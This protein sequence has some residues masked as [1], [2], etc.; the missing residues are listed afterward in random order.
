[1]AKK[2]VVVAEQPTTTT[3]DALATFRTSLAQMDDATFAQYQAAVHEES[4]LR[5]RRELDQ[6]FNLFKS[7]PREQQE[8]F[9]QSAQSKVMKKQLAAGQPVVAVSKERNPLRMY[10]DY[11]PE[12]PQYKVA[13]LVNVDL[14][15]VFT[16][17]NPKNKSWLADLANEDR[18]AQF[19]AV[20][21]LAH[22][23]DFLQALMT[24]PRAVFRWE[25]DQWVDCCPR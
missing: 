19:G 25:A 14:K 22:N 12:N 24:V 9:L 3:D 13:P 18:Y 5:Q 1:M 17:G 20:Q 8:R 23:A 7:L 21:Q 15:D 11:P 4:D 10:Q 6:V 16:G 2:T